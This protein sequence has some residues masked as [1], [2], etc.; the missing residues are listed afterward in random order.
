MA[1]AQ[2]TT[3]ASALAAATAI[4]GTIFPPDHGQPLSVHFLPPSIVPDLITRERSAW[5]AGRQRLELHI[6]RH[7]RGTN[8]PEGV[9]ESEGVRFELGPPRTLAQ[10]A[11]Q[12]GRF[13]PGLA[14][15]V[16]LGIKPVLPPQRGPPPARGPMGIIRSQLGASA[17][18]AGGG[19][20]S[21]PLGAGLGAGAGPAARQPP[22]HI[23]RQRV[24]PSRGYRKT[25]TR[26]VLFWREAP[27]YLK[28]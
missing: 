3:D 23:D 26:P 13:I 11:Q 24:E 14:S 17:N 10:V 9:H 18:G 22:P 20:N 19:A 4:E 15:A 28:A 1:C 12:Q 25:V 5:S 7:T 16:P 27:K 8:I 21:V 6:T 2:Y